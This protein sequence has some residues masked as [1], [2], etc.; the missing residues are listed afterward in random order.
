MAS[1]WS[2]ASACSPSPESF[3][4]SFSPRR[5]NVL[6][7]NS[8]KPSS[9]SRPEPISS[10]A[11]WVT[12]C[13]MRGRKT[14]KPPPRL[15]LIEWADTYRHVAAKTSAAPGRWRTAAQ[16][17]AFG[18]MHAVTERDTHKAGVKAGT[19]VLKTELLITAAGYFIPQGPSPILFIQP[20]QGAA[21]A[22][23]KERFGADSTVTPAL[24]GL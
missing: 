9:S 16:P 10:P 14:W 2:S 17:V 3:K 24:R 8:M 21:E 5:S 11:S 13:L 23:S 7:T 18:P 4:G 19:Q 12:A 22:F 15:T 1:V 6:R 20:T